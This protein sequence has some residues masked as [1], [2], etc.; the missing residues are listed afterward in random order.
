MAS[1][2]A[3]L[4]AAK[5][6]AVMMGSRNPSAARERIA[7]PDRLIQVGTVRDA[8]AFGNVVFLATP[9]EFVETAIRGAGSFNRKIVI[10]CTNPFAVGTGGPA[11]RTGFTISAAEEVAG[12]AQG[13]VVFKAFNSIYWENFN[14]LPFGS[15][16]LTCFYCGEDG[17]EKEVVAQLIRDAGLDPIDAGPLTSAR[18]LE[19]L[20]SLWMQLAFERGL[21]TD[22]ALM[23]VHRTSE[24]LTE[25]PQ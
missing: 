19:P 7:P 16:P 15:Q 8:V 22:I 1:A 23:L 14:R 5:G 3:R 12:W 20:A 6:H 2:L 13:A 18:Y 11:M 24:A 25:A 9:W 10:D 4:W 17:E 21:G